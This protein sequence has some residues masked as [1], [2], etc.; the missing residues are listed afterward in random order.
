MAVGRGR[1]GCRGVELTGKEVL[2]QVYE[3]S[4]PKQFG[5][6]VLEAVNEGLAVLGESY[7]VALC[8]HLESQYQVKSEE[9]C[10]KIE[11][12]DKALKGLFGAGAE[13]VSRQIA[14]SLY[15]KLG[16]SFREHMNWT[17]ADYIDD[18]KKAT[19][20]P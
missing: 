12:F 8:Y 18:A 9:I 7:Q 5:H 16:L 14:K 19:E 1:H 11:A 10:N 4:D 2:K 20:S 13:I 3:R 6:V 17:L 15:E